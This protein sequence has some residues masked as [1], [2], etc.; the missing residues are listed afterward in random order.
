MAATYAA[1]SDPEVAS[2][3]E[4]GEQRRH[5]GFRAIVQMLA[6]KGGLRPGIRLAR[7]TDILLV[8]LGPQLFDALANGRG[9]SIA[10]CNRWIVEVLSQQLLT[11]PE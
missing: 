10:E 4:L 2:V 7:A 11:P 1:A 5:D 9:W 8:L 3:Y 6:R